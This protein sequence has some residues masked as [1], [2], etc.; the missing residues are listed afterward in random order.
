MLDPDNV[1]DVGDEELLSRFILIKKY[2]RS[3]GVVK[4][5]AYSPYPHSDLSVMRHVLA[6]ELELWAE[7]REVARQ[8]S[9]PLLGRVDFLASIVR[10]YGLD[11]VKDPL[12]VNGRR[13]LANPNHANI[14]GYPSDKS[15]W[16]K[17]AQEFAAS[18]R[19]QMITPPGAVG[20]TEDDSADG[21]DAAETV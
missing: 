21:S 20:P 9:K 19:G 8:L 3:D 18:V 6:S 5:N 14:V 17:I 11:V 10:G 4:H 2:V 1:P 12:S 7:G 15:D 13:I 16:M